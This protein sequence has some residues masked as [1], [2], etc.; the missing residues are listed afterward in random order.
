MTVKE[1]IQAVIT[2][3]RQR[4][5]KEIKSW[6][7]KLHETEVYYGANGLYHR[8]LAA[9]EKRE[10]QLDELKDLQEQLVRTV[11]HKEI[12]PY[13]LHCNQCGAVSMTFSQPHMDYADCPCCRHSIYTVGLERTRLSV[14]DDGIGLIDAIN[15]RMPE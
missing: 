11:K 7:Q 13:I 1:K 6:N 10:R 15:G 14:V 2:K 4:L 8:Q 5:E 3:E 12:A 9:K